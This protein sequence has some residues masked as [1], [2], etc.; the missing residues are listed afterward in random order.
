MGFGKKKNKKKGRRQ[1]KKREQS[2]NVFTSNLD[3]KQWFFEN[4][5]IFFD[6]LP[7][8]LQTKY[9]VPR[10]NKIKSKELKNEKIAEIDY[11]ALSVEILS[12]TKTEYPNFKDIASPKSY[13]LHPIRPSF[14]KRKLCQNQNPRENILASELCQNEKHRQFV[15]NYFDQMASFY[16]CRY[17]FYASMQISNHWHFVSSNNRSKQRER[18]YMAEY[19]ADELEHHLSIRSPDKRIPEKYWYQRYR[20]FSKYDD[21]IKLDIESWHSVTPQQIAMD[22]AQKCECNVIVDAMCGVGGNSIAFAQFCDFVISVDID[23]KKI[24][25]AQHNAKIYGVD[26]KIQFIVGDFFKIAQM[27][28]HSQLIDVIFLSPPWGGQFY[29]MSMFDIKC[30]SN[31]GSM[32]GCKLLADKGEKCKIDKNRLYKK[33]KSIT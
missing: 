23:A 1:N 22:I 8:H 27:F 3:K 17:L 19:T 24:K 32:D 11:E 20:L 2:E 31:D 15:W 14:K 13:Y 30:L 29:Q 28:K 26:D 12:N 33:V 5:M 4:F 16:F 9:D 18:I 10:L 6:K 25:M 21:G 7:Q